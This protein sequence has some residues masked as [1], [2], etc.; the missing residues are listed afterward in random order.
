MVV[1]RVSP[2]P[3]GHARLHPYSILLGQGAKS[4]STGGHPHRRPRGC[5]LDALSRLIPPPRVHRHR[6]HGVLAPMP[7]SG[8]TSSPSNATWTSRPP[9]AAAVPHA[10]LRH[11][12]LPHTPPRLSPA[13]ALHP[14]PHS[15]RTPIPSL[16]WSP[17]PPTTSTRRPRSIQPIP[18]PYPSSTSIRPPAPERRRAPGNHPWRQPHPHPPAE[19]T[20]TSTKSRSPAHHHHS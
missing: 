12:E 7:G 6:Y 5:L 15:H 8:P 16:T 2:D 4:A 20:A 19:S 3:P 18:S 11:L 1:P 10:I 13:R 17:G 9:R 14:R